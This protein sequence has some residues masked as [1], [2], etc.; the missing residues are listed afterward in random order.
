MIVFF[1]WK[2]VYHW[3]AEGQT[4]GD[5]TAHG[6]VSYYATLLFPY[7]ITCKQ[8]VLGC[9]QNQSLALQ[10]TCLAADLEARPHAGGRIQEARRHTLL[11]QHPASPLQKVEERKKM[12]SCIT[13]GCSK[14]AAW[15][16]WVK[17]RLDQLWQLVYVMQNVHKHSTLGL[18]AKRIWSGAQYVNES[19]T[20]KLG[21]RKVKT[22]WFSSGNWFWLIIIVQFLCLLVNGAAIEFHMLKKR[23]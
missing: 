4:L 13:A 5:G 8:W 19:C 16:K 7:A 2:V 3:Q 9:I 17:S 11:N 15:E 23:V 1:F 21:W 6:L 18:L 20:L 12:L 10:L 22:C 14:Q